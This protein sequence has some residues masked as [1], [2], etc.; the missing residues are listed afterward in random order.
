MLTLIFQIRLC[1]I[2]WL[3]RTGEELD[4]KC[5]FAAALKFYYSGKVYYSKL[6]E[7]GFQLNGCHASAMIKG[8]EENPDGLYV[9]ICS[10]LKKVAEQ[11]KDWVEQHPGI[12]LGQWSE[13]DEKIQLCHLKHC[14]SPRDAEPRLD[15]VR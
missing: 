14:L 7:F 6:E 3:L 5:E 10:A 13:C 9:A 12:L 8:F 2:Q 11:N 4:R 1:H 15:A